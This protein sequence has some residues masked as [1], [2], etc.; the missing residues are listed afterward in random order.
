MSASNLA[1][2]WGKCY[3]KFLN[4]GG[5]FLESTQGEGTQVFD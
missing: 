3:R 2:E 1:S 4:V 5:I